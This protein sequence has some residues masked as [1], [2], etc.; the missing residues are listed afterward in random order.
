MRC[1]RCTSRLGRDG[2][3]ATT[4][5]ASA[6]ATAAASSG[7]CCCAARLLLLR[8][9][10][11]LGPAAAAATAGVSTACGGAQEC[12]CCHSSCF[13]ASARHATDSW[14]DE[15]CVEV[16]WFAGVRYGRLLGVTRRPTASQ[17]TSPHPAL[18][19]CIAFARNERELRQNS[20]TEL[21]HA[22]QLQKQAEQVVPRDSAGTR[23][24]GKLLGR[25]SH[26]SGG[27]TEASVLI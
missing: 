3:W 4:A 16:E 13:C 8:V 24:V 27:E 15:T 21:L 2:G 22:I 14:S 10:R 1:A 7:C 12:S 17:A 25:P 20:I 11:V 19:S 23:V 26:R 9:L 18:D 5:A 6:V